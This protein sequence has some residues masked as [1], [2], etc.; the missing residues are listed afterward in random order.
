MVDDDRIIR[1]KYQLPTLD[2]WDSPAFAY[3]RE[4][5][6][7]DR[8]ASLVS[9]YRTGFPLLALESLQTVNVNGEVWASGL[10]MPAGAAR[11]NSRG[12]LERLPSRPIWGGFLLDAAVYSAMPPAFVL[13]V[14]ALRRRIRLM[15]GLCPACGYDL[16]ATP[17][18]APCPECGRAQQS[19]SAEAAESA[20]RTTP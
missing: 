5:Q 19:P 15:R 10:P 9:S 2:R 7:Q 12:P 3:R 8:V 14:R 6:T 4:A 17:P 1:G 16:S 20:A 18:S 13:A 11:V